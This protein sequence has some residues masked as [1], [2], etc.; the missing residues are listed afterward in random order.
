MRTRRRRARFHRNPAAA[1]IAHSEASYRLSDAVVYHGRVLAIPEHFTRNALMESEDFSDGSHWNKTRSSVAADGGTDPLGGT[2]SFKLLDSV[3]NGTHRMFQLSN[4]IPVSNGEEITL[5]I[6]AKA[7]EHPA[8]EL[9]AVATNSAYIGFDSGRFDL[10]NGEVDVAGGGA[11]IQDWGNGW[12]RCSVK[13]TIN[14][15]YCIIDIRMV[16]SSGDNNFIGDG[17]DGVLIFG[18]QVERAGSPS[19]YQAI[20]LNRSMN[21]ILGDSSTVRFAPPGTILS[22]GTTGDCV[23]SPASGITSSLACAAWVRPYR[24]DPQTDHMEIGSQSDAGSDRGWEFYLSTTG[25]L[26][27]TISADGSA[28]VTGACTALLSSV[29]PASGGWVLMVWDDTADTVNFYYCLDGQ[30]WSDPDELNWEQLGDADVALA[31]AGLFNSSMNVCVGAWNDGGGRIWDGCIG[32]FK[33][34]SGATSVTDGALSS[35]TLVR[36]LQPR[37]QTDFENGNTDTFSSG[38]DTWTQ[39]SDVYINPYGQPIVKGGVWPAMRPRKGWRFLPR[40]Q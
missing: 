36:D 23:T 19:A 3:D 38:G 33:L 21:T 16:N 11:T 34:W 29:M 18:A 15:D 35:G 31:S 8:I 28:I 26:N 14:D 22:N 24:F 9:Q 12:Y 7:A 27:A 4:P 40:L 5:S 1:L 13:G 30:P 10:E 39:N 17:T 20:A 25:Y 2:D 32:R 6:F 37:L